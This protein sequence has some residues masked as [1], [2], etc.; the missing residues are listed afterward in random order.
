M[1][2]LKMVHIKKKKVLKA[3]Y[4]YR[5]SLNNGEVITILDKGEKKKDP[6]EVLS[7]KFLTVNSL[8]TIYP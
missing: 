5:W 4:P 7:T 6:W 1:G 8:K 2:T 3:V